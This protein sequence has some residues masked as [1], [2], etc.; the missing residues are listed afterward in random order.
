MDPR[1]DINRTSSPAAGAATAPIADAAAG[2]SFGLSVVKLAKGVCNRDTVCRGGGCVLGGCQRDAG[3]QQQRNQQGP[4]QSLSREYGIILTRKF[5]IAASSGVGSRAGARAARDRKVSP[6]QRVLRVRS[7]V[8][9]CEEIT[10]GAF[11]P[12]SLTNG[13]VPVLYG[14]KVDSPR[15]RQ[16]SGDRAA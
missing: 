1:C 10:V 9:D 3:N 16:R 6:H 5:T 13:A 2:N 8:R 15:R 7:V 4:H 14:Q 12:C 11:I